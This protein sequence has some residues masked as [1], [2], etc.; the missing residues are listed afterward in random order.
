VVASNGKVLDSVFALTVEAKDHYFG[1][2]ISKAEL[3]NDLPIMVKGLNGNWDAG[4][5]DRKSG[6]FRRIGIFEATAYVTLDI[7][8]ERDIFIGNLLVCDN[9]QVKLAVTKINKDGIEFEAHNPTDQ[10]APITI[11]SSK[12]LGLFPVVMKQCVLNPGESKVFV[13]SPSKIQE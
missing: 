13:T 5:Y 12:R 2:V 6:E 4:I 10:L 7:S 3:P 8:S 9:L 1:G 11:R